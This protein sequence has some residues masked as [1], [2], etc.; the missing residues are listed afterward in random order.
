MRVPLTRVVLVAA[1]A[2]ACNDP[3]PQTGALRVLVATTGGD[4]DDDGYEATVDSVPRQSVAANGSV[5]IS[6]VPAGV[7]EVA[8]RGI[9]AN[10][11]V[12]EGSASHPRVVIVT[13]RD[14]TLAAFS[15][16]CLVTGVQVTVSTGGLDPDPDGYT[17]SVDGAAPQPIPANG[18]LTI[19]RLAAGSHTLALA[20]MAGNCRLDDSSPPSVVV[21]IGEVVPLD[22]AVRCVAATGSVRVTTTTDGA[23][24]DADGYTVRVN[25]GDGSYPVASNGLVTI[26][27]L[28]GASDTLWLQGVATNCAVVG[29]NPRTVSVT[30]GG[31]TRDTVQTVFA[32]NCVATTGALTVVVE[33]SGEVLDPDGYTLIVASDCDYW[34]C[35]DL[36]RYQVGGNEVV[37][38]PSLP[39]DAYYLWMEDVARNC[40]YDVDRSTV[41]VPPGDT[42]RVSVAVTCAAPGDLQLT[43]ATTGMDADSVYGLRVTGTAFD[44]TMAVGPNATVTMTDV[45]AGDYG[46]TL[47]DVATNCAVTTPNPASTTVVGRRTAAVGFDV[48][49]AGLVTLQLSV[50]TTGVDQDPD[51]YQFVVFSDRYDTSGVVSATET[52]VFSGVPGGEYTARLND[53]AINC[54]VTPPNPVTLYVPSGGA[55]AF[56]FAVGCNQ[57][58]VLAMTL[59]GP[60]G[61][62]DIYRVKVN[63]TG[64]MQLTTGSARDAEPA[65]SPDGGRIAFVSERDGNDEVYVMNAD[66]SGLVRL[67]D[68]AAG[69]AGPAWSPDGGRIA[70]TS[71][72]DGNGEIYVMNADG[73]GLARLTDVAGDDAEP[74]WSPDGSRIAFTSNRAGDVAIYVMNADGSGATRLSGNGVIDRHPAWS[75][76]GSRLAFSRL[77]WCYEGLCDYDLYV[78]AADGSAGTQLLTWESYDTTSRTDAAW[79]PDGRWVAYG[80]RHYECP[81][82]CS[83]AYS[84]VEVVRP[85]GGEIVEIARDASGPAWRP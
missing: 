74:A 34:Y 18:T 48:T 59:P 20:G 61:T 80:A 1:L 12:Q 63:G 71:A 14:T 85:D 68:N 62:G 70:F 81:W 66:G 37:T 53:V 8:L 60:W 21:A 9:A 24:L 10:C 39:V 33:T 78:M 16:L 26:D 42:I 82:F 4:L 19:S 77:A 44:T 6:G 32:V 3:G 46:V 75:P 11:M 83:L 29:D 23:D 17:V 40:G 49:C 7:H 69:D 36:Q 47:E 30:T 52:L 50:M 5:V 27:G 67:T 64:L 84:A 76:D 54:E 73:S 55:G 13:G 56:T 51:G 43:V 31:Q 15:V 65:W 45:P 72:R 28:T 57:A 22:F 38:I 2:A 35:A 25:G 79:S 58:G 41:Y